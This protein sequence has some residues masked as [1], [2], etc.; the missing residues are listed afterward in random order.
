MTAATIE[1]MWSQLATIDDPC[2]VGMG[3][4]VDIV[5]LGLIESVTVQGTVA[6]VS[7]VLTQPTCW[8]FPAITRYIREAL[9][10]L[11]GIDDVTVTVA[12][13]LWVPE[14]MDEGSRVLVG[15]RAGHTA[16]ELGAGTG[17][18]REMPCGD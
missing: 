14:R 1:T 2:S 7:I 4:R 13:E 5:S 10:D 18:Q 9:L 11:D 3:K 17:A 12:P 15:I 16:R 8:Y 6:A